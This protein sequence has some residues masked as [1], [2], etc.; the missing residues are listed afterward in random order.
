MHCLLA[1]SGTGNC[2]L[3][4]KSADQSKNGKS[5]SDIERKSRGDFSL[6]VPDKRL[7]W[8]ITH[9]RSTF[10]FNCFLV[11]MFF[12]FFISCDF[13]WMWKCLIHVVSNT[14]GVL[15]NQN[16]VEYNIVLSVILCDNGGHNNYLITGI[17]ATIVIKNSLPPSCYCCN[18]YQYQY[19][20][21]C[22]CCYYHSCSLRY[23]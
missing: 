21:Y 12:S 5:K 4:F 19:Q 3:I 14:M 20:H 10:S 9:L 8:D 1:L 2:N 11:L 7:E 18:Y 6:S 22:H 15:I 23:I 16:N 17:T 13:S